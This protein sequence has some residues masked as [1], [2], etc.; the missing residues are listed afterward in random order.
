MRSKPLYATQALGLS[1]AVA[2]QE[3]EAARKEGDLARLAERRREKAAQLEEARER[4][5][6]RRWS[7][8]F[9]SPSF[10]P[11]F[12]LSLVRAC[13][14]HVIKQVLRKERWRAVSARE[15]GGRKFWRRMRLSI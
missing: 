10:F 14:L 4:A 15:H 9:V 3:E 7:A 6:E 2:R 5:T 1:A 13:V 12:F 8:F 11:P